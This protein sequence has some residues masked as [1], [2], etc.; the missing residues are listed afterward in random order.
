LTIFVPEL[1]LNEDLLNRIAGE[2]SLAVEE[3]P[4]SLDLSFDFFSKRGSGR[5]YLALE[6]KGDDSA[7][8]REVMQ[9]ERPSSSYKRMLAAC[10]SSV[11][12]CYR[13]L[14]VA[15]DA[16]L[17]LGAALSIGCRSSCVLDNGRGC[18]L[19]LDD[20]L[21]CIRQEPQWSW[22]REQFPELPD[23]AVSEWQ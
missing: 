18:L 14:D 8:I 1:A 21:I 10:K 23:V 19:R 2:L 11:T 15:K 17:K 16:V 3:V 12:I 13:E 20:V 5:S 7:L 6:Y 22:E 9:W 4:P